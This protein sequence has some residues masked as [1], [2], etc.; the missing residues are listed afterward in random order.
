MQFL[1]SINI[2]NAAMPVVERQ[3]D[4]KVIVISLSAFIIILVLLAVKLLFNN[5]FK[6]LIT[7][8]LRIDVSAKNFSDTN[9]AGIQASLLTGIASTLSVGTAIMTL[10]VY[11]PGFAST[12]NIKPGVLLLAT[13]GTAV[14]FV[15]LYKIS[16]WFL[17]WVLN[18]TQELSQYSD[19]TSD[20]FR[21]M[22]I[23]IFPLFLIIPFTDLWMQ[24][25]LIFS[26]ILVFAIAFI[27]RLYGF[28]NFLVK[29]K[30]FNHYAILY[31]CTFEILPV[32]FIAKI[33]GNL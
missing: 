10:V 9:S 27:V 8:V 18:Y 12:V 29:I 11:Y 24:K 20:I 13:T 17:G 1:A 14:I 23:I 3:T 2:L 19:M 15:A 26:V 28:V 33:M 30:F 5:Y 6:H 32:L 4:Y 31:F 25:L 7:N 16:L 22:G 21:V